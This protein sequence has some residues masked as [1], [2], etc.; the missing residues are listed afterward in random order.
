MAYYIVFVFSGVL[1]FI[2]DFKYKKALCIVLAIGLSIFAGTRFGI[3]SDYYM[4]LKSMR[5][6]E[7]DIPDFAG[8]EV[9]LE[10]CMFV[11][12]H[13]FKLFFNNNIEVA[14][15]SFLLF[16][17]LGVSFKITAI[18]K[19]SEF[20]FL[21]VLL[22]IGNLYLMQ[23]MTTIR[24]GVAAGIF[25][26]SIKNIE[27]REYVPFFVKLLLCFFF[28][29]SSILF[30]LPWLLFTLNVNIKYYYILV[31]ISIFLLV[32]NI[33]LLTVLMLDRIFPR[34]KLYMEMME[35]MKEDSVNIFNFK[36]LFG[37]F[38]LGVFS[39]FYTKMKN[40][41]FFDLLFK[42]HII[43]VSLFLILSVSGAQVFSTRTFEM[44]SV[45]QIILYPMLIH[46]F[47]AKLKIVGW[48]IILIFSCIQV[49]YLVEVADI[50]KEYNSWL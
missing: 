45:I 16:A 22:Y 5:Y 2:A 43:S 8:R 23:E 25:L 33:N 4:Y 6:I 32:F 7:R 17:T 31:A 21:S 37:I 19:Y 30:L 47:P 14:K 24:A 27:D 18:A 41:R 35:W 34:I 39:I 11:I 1:S 50:F 38:M 49:Y 36:M 15:A 3:D 28:H 44:Y 10:W 12:P 48:I 46:I 13:F 9:P 20:I 26:L 40:I 29:S 42:I